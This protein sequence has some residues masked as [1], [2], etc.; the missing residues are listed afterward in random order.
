MAIRS[1][2]NSTIQS[3]RR[4]TGNI[5]ETIFWKRM[6]RAL[7]W[8]ASDRCDI[9]W[10][11][12]SIGMHKCRCFCSWA[13]TFFHC[14]TN[15]ST[16]IPFKIRVRNY[17][18]TKRKPP[19]HIHPYNHAVFRI[20]RANDMA[21]VPRKKGTNAFEMNRY[22]RMSIS[23]CFAFIFLLFC[24]FTGLCLVIWCWTKSFGC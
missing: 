24:T 9:W 15:V 1:K 14:R 18:G 21:E 12:Q 4:Q 22:I 20:D 7:Q 10:Y 19:F 3:T 11:S 17:Y 6:E 23:K 2:H 8:H 13:Y 5:Y 16:L